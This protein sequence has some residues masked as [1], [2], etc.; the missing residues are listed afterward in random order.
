MLAGTGLGE[1]RVEGIVAT[2]DCLFGGHLPV[3]LDA[4]LEAEEFPA[5]VSNLHTGLPD[6]DADRLTHCAERAS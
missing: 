6:L 5:C 4:V 3:K 2:S 1:E